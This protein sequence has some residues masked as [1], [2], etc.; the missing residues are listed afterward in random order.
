MWTDASTTAVWNIL[1]A[2]T[3]SILYTAVAAVAVVAAGLMGVGYGFRLVKRH[4]TG[5]KF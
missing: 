1:T 3:G 4:I 2:S 5:R